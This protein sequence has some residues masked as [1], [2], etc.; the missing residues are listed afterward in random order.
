MEPTVRAEF[1]VVQLLLHCRTAPRPLDPP[2]YAGYPSPLASDTGSWGGPHQH[3]TEPKRCLFGL[4]TRQLD[5]KALD[6]FANR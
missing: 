2:A 3:K 1:P 4:E 6:M 5:R